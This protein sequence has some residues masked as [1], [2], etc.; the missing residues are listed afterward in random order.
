MNFYRLYIRT[1]SN[2]IYNK[3][4]EILNIT[5][6]AIGDKDDDETLW[7]Y[8]LDEKDEDEYIDFINIYLDVLEPKFNVLENIGIP[9]EDISIWRIYE[10]TQQCSMEIGPKEM[11]R[12]GNN[13]ITLCID[14]YEK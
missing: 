13:G 1:N 14:C 9:R 8:A 10:Y 5:P 2:D 12:L 7:C 11:K 6:N 4:S 3:V